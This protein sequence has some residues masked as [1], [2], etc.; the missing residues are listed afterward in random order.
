MIRAGDFEETAQWIAKMGMTKG[1]L[2]YARGRCKELEEH[3]SG[4]YLGL[5]KRV[6][7]IIEDLN[8]GA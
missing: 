6:R 4:L 2:D 5:R 8:K 7:E 3:E 1:W